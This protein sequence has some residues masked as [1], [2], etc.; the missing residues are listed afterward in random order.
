MRAI[1]EP[2]GKAKEYCDLA[3][4]LYEGCPHGCT[5]CYVPAILHKTRERFA[6]VK[7]RKGIIKA[8]ESQ[9][10]K[11][12]EK[13]NGREVFLCFTCDPYPE[14]ET[15]YCIT[16][17]VIK[18]L[19]VNGTAVRILTKAGKRSEK[20]FDLLAQKPLLSRYGT[21]LV[22]VGFKESGVYEADAPSSFE[23][24]VALRD[25]YEREIPTWVSLEPVIDPA[26]SLELIHL[27][28]EFTDEYKVGKLNHNRELEQKI[29]REYGWRRFTQE[30]V[31]LLEKYGKKYYIKQDLR[32]YL[33]K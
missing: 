25:A 26:Q 15:D 3:L 6:Q 8:L 18:A 17:E 10:E 21:T 5:Y 30:S 32:R 14:I 2:Q 33:E 31:G 13:F 22:F 12:G 24:I 16:T 23:R 4:N 1:Y 7:P 28:H 20:D 19:H 27:T 9:L 29:D 11:E